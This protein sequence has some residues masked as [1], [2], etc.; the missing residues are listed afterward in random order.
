MSN[1][2]QNIDLVKEFKELAFHYE[3]LRKEC[4]EQ[5]DV[6]NKLKSEL[7]N[8][9]PNDMKMD[10]LLG[11]VSFL[12]ELANRKFSNEQYIYHVNIKDT[13]FAFQDSIV[14]NTVNLVA[15]ELNTSYSFD[16]INFK[17]GDIVVDIG[18]NIGMVSIFL[19]KMYPFLKIYAFEPV[20][21]NYENFLE[22]IKLNNIPKG[23]ITVENKAV[24]KDGRAVTMRVCENNSGG[25][26]LADVTSDKSIYGYRGTSINVESITLEEIFAKHKINELKLLKI[27]CEGS[28]YEILYN[29]K[30]SILK[31]IQNLIGEFHKSECLTQ[32]KIPYTFDD[33]L[34]HCEKYIKN[35]NV[36]LCS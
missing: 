13:F 15:N 31:N 3:E 10:A 6:I 25:A 32:D 28:E 16:H 34:K 12:V 1:N 33:L 4:V 27:D 23:T 11:K 20:R 19:A 24:T 35:I 5:V 21:E 7:E 18:G 9:A 36:G 17:E 26:T 2:M 8:K 14:S 29:T 22:N 30:E